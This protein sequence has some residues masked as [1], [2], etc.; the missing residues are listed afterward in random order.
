ML[1]IFTIRAWIQ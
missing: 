1:L